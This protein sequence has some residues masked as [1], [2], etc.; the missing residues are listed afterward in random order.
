[1]GALSAPPNCS[2][3]LLVSS[4]TVSL[5]VFGSHRPTMMWHG[6]HG[7]LAVAAAVAGSLAV[8]S[9]VTPPISNLVSRSL[10]FAIFVFVVISA[11]S[12]LAST[13]VQRSYAFFSLATMIFST[14]SMRFP[15]APSRV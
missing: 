4:I 7:E 9:L 12:V 1:M 10:I 8:S 3:H 2:I 6:R 15:C 13:F 14:F 11:E 5:G